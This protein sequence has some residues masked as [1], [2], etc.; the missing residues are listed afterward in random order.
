[1]IELSS[2]AVV[3]LHIRAVYLYAKNLDVYEYT[4]MKRSV[5]FESIYENHYD[6]C[7]R[8][9]C[10]CSDFKRNDGFAKEETQ[11]HVFRNKFLAMYLIQI[12]SD[13]LVKSKNREV[14]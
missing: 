3:N 4:N 14:Y 5:L 8:T 7:T 13:H 1:M 10:F 12:F 11:G 2:S 9:D 6:T